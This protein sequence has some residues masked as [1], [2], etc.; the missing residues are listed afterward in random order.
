MK[1]QV[2]SPSISGEIMIKLVENYFI[3]IISSTFD[4]SL[5]HQVF[6]FLICI[7]NF[8]SSNNMLLL[9]YIYLNKV[10]DSLIDLLL[11][12][13]DILIKSRIIY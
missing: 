3:Q 11:K 5:S 10:E 7:F 1:F 13:S 12:I 8:Y 2:F 9:M 4:K 6:S